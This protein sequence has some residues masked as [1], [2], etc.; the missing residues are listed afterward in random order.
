[1]SPRQR[2]SRASFRLGRGIGVPYLKQGLIYFTCL[3]YENLPVR[4]QAYIRR[5]CRTCGKS[6]AKALFE[7]MTKEGKSMR[8]IVTEGRMMGEKI[9][10]TALYRCK[11]AFYEGWEK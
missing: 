5:L 3:N 11:K 6:H 4:M 10:E 2:K 8:R 9:S 1:M 7:L